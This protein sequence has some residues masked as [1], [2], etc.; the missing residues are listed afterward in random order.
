MCG[1]ISNVEIKL[2][3]EPIHQNWAKGEKRTLLRR[4]VNPSSWWSKKKRNTSSINVF[5]L[6]PP[7]S[8]SIAMATRK[9]PQRNFYST[10]EK[11]KKCFRNDV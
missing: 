5:P 3:F 1:Q 8:I 9:T 6:P 10:K 11:Q 2:L 4:R 7:F